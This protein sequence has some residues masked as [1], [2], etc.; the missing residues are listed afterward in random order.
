MDWTC[1]RVE[2]T[3]C[4]I[5]FHPGSPGGV[6]DLIAT[7]LPDRMLRDFRVVTTGIEEIEIAEL[8]VHPRFFETFWYLVDIYVEWRIGRIADWETWSSLDAYAEVEAGKFDVL[9][10]RNLPRK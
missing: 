2:E 4:C 9:I 3:V 8:S 7:Q 1:W 6:R 10:F 5:C